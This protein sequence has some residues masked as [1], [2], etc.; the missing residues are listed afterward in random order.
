MTLPDPETTAIV[1]RN[2]LR[3]YRTNARS[4]VWRSSS[5]P[6]LILIS[7]VMLQQT[8]VARVEQKLPPFLRRFPDFASLARATKADVVRAWQ[9][10]GYNSRA[11]RLRELAAIVTARFQ[12]ALP[13]NPDELQKLPGIGPYTSHA[14]ACFAFRKR[15][16]LVDVNVRRL[17][18]RLFWKMRSP[19]QTKAEPLIWEIAAKVLPRDAHSWNQGLMD[20]GSL[21]CTLRHPSC[22]VCPVKS[23][24][25]SSSLENSR[26]RPAR[27]SEAVEPRYAGIARRI[28]RGK[29]V[30]QLRRLSGNRQIA[31]GT[32]GSSVKSDFSSADV[33]W[34]TDLLSLLER[35]G[36]VAITRLKNSTFIRLA[37]S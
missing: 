20:F 37:R 7:E 3:W 5:D 16:P 13:E 25:R 32:L 17:F 2:I 11:L 19:E 8:Q 22:G 35:D 18:S 14:V 6:Y 29:I 12:G 1:R 36:I 27:R 21:I 34:L 9:G 4:F 30:E 26:H 24:C 28:W 15:A 31:I 23:V 33:P 10:M